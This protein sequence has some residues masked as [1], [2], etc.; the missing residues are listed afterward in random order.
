MD[1]VKHYEEK[2]GQWFTAYSR[3]EPQAVY[4]ALVSRGIKTPSETDYEELKLNIRTELQTSEKF[5][6][7]QYTKFLSDYDKAIFS[8]FRKS[9]N[10]FLKSF[11][12]VVV[13]GHIVIRQPI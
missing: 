8:H 1:S 12:L 4:K 13:D 6:I 3:Y 9:S 5:K 10:A 7:E 11:G 2:K